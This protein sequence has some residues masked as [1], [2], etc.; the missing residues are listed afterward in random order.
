MNSKGKISEISE[1][2]S[3][4]LSTSNDKID[5]KTFDNSKPDSAKNS[6]TISAKMSEKSAAQKKND[7][8]S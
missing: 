4:S 1:P 3:S 8:I 5:E 6:L 7:L 2:S